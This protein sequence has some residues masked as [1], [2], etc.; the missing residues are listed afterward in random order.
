MFRGDSALESESEMT[1]PTEFDVVTRFGNGQVFQKTNTSGLSVSRMVLLNE[2][3]M[4]LH[5]RILFPL[6]F[7]FQVS[8]LTGCPMWSKCSHGWDNFQKLMLTLTDSLT[9]YR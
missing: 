9:W 1:E 8:H 3:D 6:H 4:V 5:V 7:F 2:F